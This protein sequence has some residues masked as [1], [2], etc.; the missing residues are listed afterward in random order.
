MTNHEMQR[1]LDH[2]AQLPDS[3]ELADLADQAETGSGA[4]AVPQIQLDVAS[5]VGQ[6]LRRVHTNGLW[7][8]GLPELFIDPPPDYHPGSERGWAR[9][10]FLL[11]SALVCLGHEL[12]RA[13]NFEIAPHHDVFHEEPVRFWLAGAEP[14]D[15][16]LIRAL[17]TLVHT[18]IRVQC[19]LWATE[20][21]GSCLGPAGLGPPLG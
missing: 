9:L 12:R 7:W 19:S 11:A 2:L 4:A 3:P 10:A 20:P 17:G 1:Y 16:E 15:E 5:G 18:V 21:D 8:A 6:R 14:P 13:E